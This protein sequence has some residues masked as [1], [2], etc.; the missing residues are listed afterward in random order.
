MEIKDIITG[1]EICQEIKSNKLDN[2]VVVIP[3]ERLTSGFK[4]LEHTEILSQLSKESQ[5][6]IMRDEITQDLFNQLCSDCEDVSVLDI[7]FKDASSICEYT[8]EDKHRVLEVLNDDSIPAEYK[9]FILHYPELKGYLKL[10]NLFAGLDTMKQYMQV[11]EQWWFDNRDFIS[12]DIIISRDFLTKL[13]DYKQAV[14]EISISPDLQKALGIIYTVYKYSLEHREYCAIKSAVADINKKLPAILKCLDEDSKQ[15]FINNWLSNNQLSYDLSV[16]HK[17]INKIGDGSFTRDRVNYIAF[18][19]KETTDFDVELWQEDIVIY[20]IANKKKAF[21]KLIKSNSDTFKLVRKNSVLLQSE[22]YTD[23]VNINTLNTKDIA[24]LVNMRA[25]DSKLERLSGNNLTFPE[26]KL[27]YYAPINTINLYFNLNIDSVDSRLNVIRE[28]I[29]NSITV[30]EEM[31]EELPKYLCQKKLSDWKLEFSNIKRIDYKTTVQILMN[32]DNMKRF[33]PHINDRTEAIRLCQNIS[34]YKDMLSIEDVRNSVFETDKDWLELKA[35]LQLT[36]TFVNENKQN[37]LK[38]IMNNGAEIMYR[39]LCRNI[40]SVKNVQRLVVA[41]ITDK[42]HELK[43]HDGDLNKEIDKVVPLEKQLIWEENLT[44]Q[45]GTLNAWEED[46]LIPVMQIGEVPRHTCLSYIDGTYSDCLLSNFDSNKKVIYVSLGE[47]IIFRASIRLT[48]SSDKN[49]KPKSFEFVDVRDVG[50][51]AGI[52]DCIEN[53]ILFLERPYLKDGYSE[54]KT[55]IFKLVFSML[56][57]KAKSMGIVLVVSQDYQD[58]QT[59]LT[60]TNYYIY[61]SA[62]KAGKQY[63]D[64]LGGEIATDAEGRYYCT[65]VFIHKDDVG[66][67]R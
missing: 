66:L 30:T 6:N 7:F 1:I 15:S 49:I 34:I 16:I 64:S 39:Y 3:Q 9:H 31:E 44:H 10:D 21:L 22:F 48:K 18:C 58:W 54:Y 37:I 8:V 36:D 27:L 42:F 55:N 5:C 56:R 57:A 13:K 33:I 11:S 23:C 2:C 38:F 51:S 45:L 59:V 17:N 46:K 52:N 41:E 60:R 26:F 12:S 35:K 67:L 65:D 19:Y 50:G 61:I 28:F 43:Y 24:D 40:T 53:T 4:K 20:A 25:I 29:S 63:L 62:S 14:I 32:Y 47:Q